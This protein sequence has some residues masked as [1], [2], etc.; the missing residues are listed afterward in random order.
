[1]NQLQ[2][3]FTMMYDSFVYH[4]LYFS[5]LLQGPFWGAKVHGSISGGRRDFQTVLITKHGVMEI[6]VGNIYDK[7]FRKRRFPTLF[8]I[9]RLFCLYLTPFLFTFHTFFYITHVPPI[10]H[11]FPLWRRLVNSGQFTW[12]REVRS[13][14]YYSPTNTHLHSRKKRPIGGTKFHSSLGSTHTT[15]GAIILLFNTERFTKQETL[16]FVIHK[17]GWHAS[18]NLKTPKV[19][20]LFLKIWNLPKLYS[21]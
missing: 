21:T 11:T 9:W 2:I 1:M 12:C 16:A 13:D 10:F 8:Y 6:G 19:F 18:Q 17:Q 20:M 3:T 14:L 5:L 15:C 4:I 7:F